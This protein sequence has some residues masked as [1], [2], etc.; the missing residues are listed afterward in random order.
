MVHHMAEHS[1]PE[2]GAALRCNTLVHLATENVNTLR[3]KH[4][5]CRT[6]CKSSR[7]VRMPS[8]KDELLAVTTARMRSCQRWEEGVRQRSADRGRAEMCAVAVCSAR[9]GCFLR[10][11]MCGNA[12]ETAGRAGGGQGGFYSNQTLAHLSARVT[13]RSSTS[14]AKSQVLFSQDGQENVGQPQ[15]TLRTRRERVSKRQGSQHRAAWAA[16]SGRSFEER[17][18]SRTMQ[19]PGKV[20]DLSAPSAAAPRALSHSGLLRPCK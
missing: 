10:G 13:S 15:S 11:M 7:H 19:A 20:L 3:P 12:L 18:R 9:R 16:R 1:C 6:S 2:H 17:P 14:S 5:A 4:P 8:R